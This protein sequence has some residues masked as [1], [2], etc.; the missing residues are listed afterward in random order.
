MGGR[1]PQGLGARQHVS[2]P[3]LTDK[4]YRYCFLDFDARRE[5]KTDSWCCACQKD[6]KGG[7]A[8]R[9]VHLIHGGAYVLHPQDEAIYA[10]LQADPE[11][12]D[13]GDVYSFRIGNDCARKLGLEWSVFS[14]DLDDL[15]RK[16]CT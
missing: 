9:W 16:A 11:T 3:A 2:T 1:C 7:K 5:P 10:A 8:Y 13:R 14:P 6:L 4:P 12:Q 15:T